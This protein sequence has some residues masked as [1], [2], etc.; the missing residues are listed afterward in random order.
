MRYRRVGR[1]DLTVSVLGLGTT[2]WGAHR[3]FGDVGLEDAKRHVRM[4]LDAGVNL[5][6][7]AETYGDGRCEEL[8]G[9]A[10]GTRRDEAV[11]ASKAFFGTSHRPGEF[12]LTRRHLLH[13]CEDSLRRLRTDRLDLLQMHGWDGR[14]PLEETLSALHAL[15]ESG[16][17]RH[18]GVSNWSAWHLMKALAI[19]DRE[20]LP[21][22]VAQQIYYSLQARE[23]EFELVPLSL[24]QSVGILV[25]SPLAG[26]LLTG[27][28]RRGAAPPEGTRRMLGWPDPPIYDEERLWSTI[29]ALVGIADGRGCSVPEVALAY[30]LAKPGVTSLIIGAR[31][32]E[33]LAQNL[34]AADLELEPEELDRLE[35]VSAPPLPYPLWWQAK[36]DDLLGEADLALL[37]RYRS[38]P[39]SEGGLHRPLPGFEVIPGRLA[40]TVSAPKEDFDQA[41]ENG[42][43]GA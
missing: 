18:V 20:G 21:R 7:T 25:W 24:D 36:Y 40:E 3:E 14:T 17:V 32:D 37:G 13:S 23:A 10:L 39:V 5:F 1:S 38:V 11:I 30:L 16:K 35:A 4:A 6:D 29:D 31:T 15:V 34:P 27:K 41:E 8:L 33:Q 2:G 22:F 42:N 26:A 9:E 19:S 28:W 43:A 12:G